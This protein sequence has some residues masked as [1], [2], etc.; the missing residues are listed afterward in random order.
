[1]TQ[2][3]PIAY[4][5]DADSA[6]ASNPGALASIGNMAPLARG[7]YGTIGSVAAY[8]ITG[9]NYLY[10]K[11]FRQLAGG[12]RFMVFRAGDIDEYG[13]TGAKTNRKTGASAS[14][15]NWSAAA[16]GD[17]IIATN[18]IDPV[19]S[20]VSGAFTDLTGTG[21]P[22]KARLVAANQNFVMVADYVNGGTYQDGWWCSGIGNHTS[23]TANPLVTQ[24]TNGRLLDVP[25][26]IR[27][28]VAYKDAF[29]AFKDN[30]IILM[31]YIGPPL[32]W[33]ARTISNS[34]GCHG[35][36]AVC[37]LRGILYFLHSSGV[38]S[39]DG[40]NVVS[41]G[42]PVEN[43]LLLL[44]NQIDRNNGPTQTVAADADIA[45]VQAVADDV[46]NVVWFFFS[47]RE[48]NAA[49]PE[50]GTEYI[51]KMYGFGY[52]V[53][54]QKWSRMTSPNYAFR[55]IPVHATHSEIKA[56]GFSLYARAR[57]LTIKTPAATSK[58]YGY[59]YP[60][61]TT[62]SDE[63]HGAGT[64]QTGVLGEYGKAIR[65]VRAYWHTAYDAECV[66]T[67][68]VAAIACYGYMNSAQTIAAGNATG[69]VNSG[70][71]CGDVQMAAPFLDVR[72]TTPATVPCEF[73]GI[74]IELKQQGAR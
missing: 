60:Y 56:S 42:D 2:I 54:S 15:T 57:L 27:A 44:L 25:G 64:L 40:N 22:P 19:Q 30:A 17:A 29:V 39:F 62:T 16:F 9:T 23:W 24:A 4:L 18:Y 31:E 74:G 53:Q 63:T 45:N 52:N 46:E 38:Y 12:V 73:H 66:N 33:S 61:Q 71:D 51:C 58:L 35:M 8:E 36:H 7:S 68:Q 11:M 10:A 72:L 26:P 43:T 37:E 14:T 48:A 49:Y 20:S 67:S 3:L 5:P 13:T 34:V 69:V 50:S 41:I 65:S 28:L 32:V 47:S 70:L 55:P 21:S 59:C 6:W 1:M